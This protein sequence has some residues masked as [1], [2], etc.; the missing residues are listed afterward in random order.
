MKINMRMNTIAIMFEIFRD[1]KNNS[2]DRAKLLNVLAH[3]DYEFEFGRYNQEGLP[4]ALISKEEY[5]DFIENFTTKS[6][7]EIKNPRL[8]MRY[9]SYHMFLDKLDDYEE[10]IK[11]MMLIDSD[12]YEKGV[13]VVKD[14]M[15]DSSELSDIDI[16]FTI[17]VGNSFGWAYKNG[18]HFDVIN[19]FTFFD[20]DEP[21]VYE[22][23]IGHELHHRSFDKL[24]TTEPKSAEEHFYCFLAYEGLAV[25]YCNNG[26]TKLTKPFNPSIKSNIGMDQYTWGYF[27]EI[28][29]EL[30]EKFQSDV[31]RLRLE[32]ES[33]LQEVMGSWLEIYRPE[34]DKS[35][36]P[37]LLHTMNYIIGSEI[38]GLIHDTYGK[39]KLYWILNNLGEFSKFYNNALES[40]GYEHY[41][42]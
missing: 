16:V 41:K 7:E 23:F 38:W 35:K 28:Y 39:E 14:A 40:V 33:C 32:G 8:K 36:T 20:I 10:H 2:Y 30:H 26:S 42:I 1:I 3:P 22:C 4:M 15:P 12:V 24:V 18:I 13:Q 37:V 31:K 6:I 21:N 34:D 5:I 27:T 11:K 19:F 9:E 25:K 29:D 17:S